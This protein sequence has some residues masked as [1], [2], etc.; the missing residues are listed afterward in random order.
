MTNYD[1]QQPH[2]QQPQYGPQPGYFQQQGPTPRRRKKPHKV[3]NTFLGIGAG[4]VALIVIGVATSSGGSSG[5]RESTAVSDTSSTTA[6]S[7]AQGAGNPVPAPSPSPTVV[8]ATKV[9]FVIS[10]YAPSDPACGGGCG[11]EIDYGSDSDTHDAQP[12]SIDGT[13]TYTVPFDPDAEFYSV[14]VTTSTS[15]SHVTCKIVAV[16][17]SPD[18][19]TTVSSGSETGQGICSAQASL[20]DSSGDSWQNEQ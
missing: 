19:P 18:V 15:S 9:E 3:R 14:D 12:D 10:G 16:G 6:A 8:P 7:G 4:L 20:E 13:V 1:P 17:P 11:P 2:P 5:G